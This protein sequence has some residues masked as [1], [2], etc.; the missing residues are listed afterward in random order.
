LWFNP[1]RETKISKRCGQGVPPEGLLGRVRSPAL[2][3][4]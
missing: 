3:L 2:T 4:V 1:L